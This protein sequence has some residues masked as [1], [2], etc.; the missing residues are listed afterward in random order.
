MCENTNKKI[1]PC[2]I[3][4]GVNGNSNTGVAAILLK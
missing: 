2:L 1:Y 3:N 4:Q